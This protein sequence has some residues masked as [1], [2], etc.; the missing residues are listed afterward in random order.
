[1]SGLTAEQDNET[2]DYGTTS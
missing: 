1:M 2:T